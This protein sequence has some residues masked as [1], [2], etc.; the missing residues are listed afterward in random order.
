MLNVWQTKYWYKQIHV[1]ISPPRDSIFKYSSFLTSL[2]FE[3]ILL[4]Q[5]RRFKCLF[6]FIYC[7]VFWHCIEQ[8]VAVRKQ[9]ASDFS[10][11]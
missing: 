1:T 7:I 8:R 9:A 6:I 2:S 11:K 4:L 10:G 5:T 3:I